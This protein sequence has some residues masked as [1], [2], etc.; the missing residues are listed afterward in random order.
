MIKYFLLLLFINSAAF[1]CDISFSLNKENGTSIKNASLV[2]DNKKLTL[3]A[4]GETNLIDINKGTY[5]IEIY[6]NDELIDTQTLSIDCTTKHYQIIV[7]N[8]TTEK[9]EEVIIRSQ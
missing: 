2:I 8:D 9:L 7:L 5:Y 4:N 3:N 1:A 6:E